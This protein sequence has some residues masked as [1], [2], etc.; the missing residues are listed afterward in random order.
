MDL[1]GKYDFVTYKKYLSAAAKFSLGKCEDN[2]ECKKNV[3]TL[4]S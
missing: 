4:L 3:P 1:K 2:N